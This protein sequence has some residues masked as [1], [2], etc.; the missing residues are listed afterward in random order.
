M[1]LFQFQITANIPWYPGRTCVPPNTYA[2]ARKLLLSL[3]VIDE[4]IFR[5]WGVKVRKWAQK[6]IEIEFY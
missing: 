6:L 2:P 1:E 5:P 3:F 4:Y